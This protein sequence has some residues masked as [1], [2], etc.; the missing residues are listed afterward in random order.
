MWEIVFFSSN[1]D[2]AKSKEY[3]NNKDFNTIILLRFKK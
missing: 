3:E 2:K 1:N